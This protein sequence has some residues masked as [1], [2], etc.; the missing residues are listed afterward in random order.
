VGSTITY[1][2]CGGRPPSRK[3]S[4][5]RFI[6]SYS[7]RV[8]VREIRHENNSWRSKTYRNIY[9][10]KSLKLPQKIAHTTTECVILWEQNVWTATKYIIFVRAWWNKTYYFREIVKPSWKYVGTFTKIWANRSTKSEYITDAC[11][12]NSTKSE[13]MHAHIR[14]TAHTN[15]SNQHT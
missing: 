14:S 5:I 7:W 15:I 6:K 8:T 11:M 1:H 10:H 2:F 12:I 13:K 9:F 4:I 3:I